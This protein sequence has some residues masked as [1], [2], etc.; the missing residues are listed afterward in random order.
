MY[1]KIRFKDQMGREIG[2]SWPPQRI[3]SLVPSQTELLYYLGLAD[4]VVGITKFCEHPQEWYKNKPKVGGTKQYH[5]DRIAKLKPD[6]IIGN[7]EENNQKQIEELAKAYPIWMS[8]IKTLDDAL[9]MIQTIGAITDH[10]HRA[11][12]LCEEINRA[13]DSL[14]IA[15]ESWVS[16]PSVAYLIWRKP[17]MVAAS[18]TFINHLLQRAGFSN[19]FS[20]ATRYPVISEQALSTKNPRFIFLSSE[21]Y[22]FKEK[23]LRELQAL[24]P[25]SVIKLVDGAL[26]SWYG[27][28]LLLAASYFSNL[29]KELK[30]SFN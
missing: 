12:I 30:T 9:D 18:D 28:R 4:R 24:C 27:N 3:I 7:K 23:H 10:S 2:L 25:Q 29:H 6:L 1:Q 26:F 21:P 22:P 20:D 19:I 16:P 11:T 8:D 13:F 15:S 17:Y 5:I 14:S